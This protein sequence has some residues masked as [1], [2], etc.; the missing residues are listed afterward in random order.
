MPPLL[1]PEWAPD[2]PDLGATAREALGVIP[3]EDGYRPFKALATTTNALT[4]R[5]QGAAWFRAPDNTTKNFAGDATKLYL[6]SGA[7][8]GN[9]SRTVGGAYGITADSNWRFAQFGN[10]AYATD[11]VDA[12]QSFDL[13]AGTNWAAASGS[14][15]V[16]VFIGTVRRFLVLANISGYQQR[17]NWSG[18]NNSNTWASSATTLADYQDLPD[19]GAITGFVGGE[20]GLVFQ[21][22]AITRMTFEGSPTVF[23][24]D[25]IANDL[26]AT[27]P[28]SVCGGPDMAFFC[29]RSGFHMVKGGQQITPIGRGKVDRWFWGQLDQ[30]NLHRV[31]TAIDPINGLYIVSFP[32]NTTPTD[33]LIYNW[34]VDRWSRASTTCEL[35]YSGATQ[36]SYTLE[37]LDAFGTV[38]TLPYSMDSSYWTGVRNLLLAG[39][40]TDHKYGAF[41]GDNHAA[42]IDTPEI[43]LNPGRRSRIWSARALVDGGT[44]SIAVGTRRTQ[45]DSVTWTSARSATSDGLVPLRAEGRYTRF[46]VTIPAAT[47]YQWA[48]GVD[49]IA[50]APGGSR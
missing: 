2:A 29:H 1:F 16:G 18:D 40:Y 47:S 36:Q 39:F 12:L 28:N 43:Q 17:V 8:W 9:V 21:E 35:I 31:T 20:L 50:G 5:C 15:P 33:M 46:R 7:T 38:D 19:G 44:P 24:F 48:R 22:S 4:A 3:G 23:R 32:T 34:K 49:E 41:S 37:D 30:S 27:L 25:K 42:T 14:P 10:T 13:S 6:L 11:G 45:Q 26:G